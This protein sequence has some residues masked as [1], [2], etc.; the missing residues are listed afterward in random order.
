MVSPKIRISQYLMQPFYFQ[1]KDGLICELTPYWCHK[2]SKYLKTA[3]I[4]GGGKFP[5]VIFLKKQIRE[6]SVM[7][8]HSGL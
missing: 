4:M 6:S 2:L 8:L 7:L 1:A 3:E 5:Y